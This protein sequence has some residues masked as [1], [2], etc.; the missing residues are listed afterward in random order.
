VGRGGER[1]GE[2][3]DIAF[4][5][6]HSETLYHRAGGGGG[7]GGRNFYG[8]FSIRPREG[9]GRV[10]AAGGGPGRF[11]RKFRRPGPVICNAALY[12]SRESRGCRARAR[13]SSGRALRRDFAR[14]RDRATRFRLIN[15]VLATG[16]RALIREKRERESKVS[17]VR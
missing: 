10:A 16:R 13:T 6:G 15:G 3:R 8:R 5:I 4:G 17:T 14:A 7:D 11:A 12:R 9:W 1:E 2:T